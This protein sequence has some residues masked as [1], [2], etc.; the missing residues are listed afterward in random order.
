[1]LLAVENASRVSFAGA[2]LLG[3]APLALGV[4]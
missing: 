2:G 4:A 1:M 3:A